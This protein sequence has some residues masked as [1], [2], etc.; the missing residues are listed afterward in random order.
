[1]T[2]APS[3]AGRPRPLWHGRG[4]ALLAVVLVALNLRTAVAALSPIFDRIGDDIALGAVGIG[5][6]GTLPPV[7]FAVVGLF[8]PALHR[9][10]G[11]ER[12]MVFSLVAI[13]LGH[14]LRAA[15]SSYPMLVLTSALTFA[16]MGVANVLLPP[17]VKKYFP[18]RIGL[19]TGLYATVMA[20]GATLPPLVAV[21]F[22]EASGWRVSVGLWAVFAVLAL[23]PLSALLVATRRAGAPHGAPGDR[24]APGTSGTEGSPGAEGSP[25]DVRPATV[26]R[27]FRSPIAWSLMLVFALTSVNAYAMFAWLPSLLVDLAGVTDA[28]S[29]AL[30]SLFSVMGLPAALI[31]P[32]LAARLRNV[33]P[34][35]GAGVVFY[36]LGYGG[37]LLLPSGPVWLWVAFVGLGP[38]LFPLSLALINLR[39]RTHAGSVALSS[40][41][42][43]FG[44]GIGA[45]GP[46]VVGVLHD[47][48]GGWTV[49]LVV[50]IGTALA[51]TVSGIVVA[52]PRMLEDEWQN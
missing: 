43:S 40:F 11:V 51:L 18:D 5:L 42:Q 27:L 24:P 46:L 1:M 30:L 14:L 23:L 3:A 39:T 20:I 37:L 38:L 48:T 49:P 12:V 13:L 31:V 2:S 34:L 7:S 45:L 28:Q 52:R 35:I 29:G 8:A 21:Q 9:R 10:F 44:Y 47:A 15:S 4:L 41:V 26:R 33:G 17:L 16:G 19:L 25:G 50:L 36:L 32:V 6:L 22:A